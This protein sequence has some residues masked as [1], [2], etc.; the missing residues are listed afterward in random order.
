MAAVPITLVIALAPSGCGS[1]MA[2]P[3]A[4]EKTGPTGPGSHAGAATATHHPESTGSPL[5]GKVIVLDPGHNGGNAS[6]PDEVNRLVNVITERK[7]CDTTGTETAAGY[8]EHAF[9]WD[10]ANRLAKVLRAQGATVVLTRRSDTGVGPCITERAA[11]GNKNKADAVLSIHADGAPRSD[12]GFHVIEPIPIKGHNAQ[13]VP[14][15]QKLGLAI[16]DAFH[17]GTDLPYSNYRGRQAIDKR[18]D[19][20]GLNLSTRPKVF[21]ECGNM[22]NPGDA[23]KLSDPKFRQRIAQSLAGGFTAYFS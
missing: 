22:A 6:H 19:L 8:T 7:P 1:R 17:T 5:R 3:E 9:T 14:D 23:A 4:S 20:G 18:N 13:I 2:G 21:I 11:I 12:H 16:R 10:V 15:S